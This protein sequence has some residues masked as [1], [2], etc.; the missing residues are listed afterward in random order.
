MR[1]AMFVQFALATHITHRDCLTVL[2]KA[3]SVLISHGILHHLR[4]D[5]SKVNSHSLHPGLIIDRLSF[6]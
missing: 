2:F 3:A 6:S 4:R 1:L 5:N